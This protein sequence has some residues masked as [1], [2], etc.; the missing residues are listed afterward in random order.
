MNE[1][2]ISFETSDS[3]KSIQQAT[4]DFAQKEIKPIIMK[5]DESQEFPRELFS[6]LGEMGY[7]GAV[8]SDEF[9]GAS[10]SHIDFVAIIEEIA[11]IDP[12][13]ALSVSAHN[14]L[15]VGHINQFGSIEQKKKFLPDLCSGKKLGGWG[16][17]EAFSG[18][19]AGGMKTF[20]EKIS[21]G[22]I[23]NGSKN[24]I[25]HGSVGETFVVL[26]KTD[27][28]SKHKNISAFIVEKSMKG[29]SVGKKEN[30][31]GMRSSDTASI[32]FSD[33][34]LP[35]ENLIGEVGKGFHQ[36][37]GVLDGGR[38]GIAALSVGLAQGALDASLKYSK[39]RI[40]FGHAI[41]DF[42]AIQWKLAEMGTEIS[43]ARLLTYKAAHDRMLGKDFHLIA[44]EAKY[45]ASE[46]AVKCATESV[47]IFGG[48][49]YI[50]DFPVEKFYRDAKLLTIGEGTSEVQKMVIARSVLNL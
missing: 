15:C 17:T 48:Y 5:Y 12:S 16:L 46:V 50:K 41:G 28:E 36:T 31:L 22:W 26:A 32:I 24:F 44:A 23:L 13:V 10:L 3:T 40:Q 21:G 33:L 37:L 18:S 30:K 19:D 14:G 9:G 11:K 4:R 29:F 39:E 42:Q 1:Q 43:A 38:I 20:A 45:F 8:V 6:K 34:F 35:D 47:Q 2:N 27:R 7:L 25:T 49:G